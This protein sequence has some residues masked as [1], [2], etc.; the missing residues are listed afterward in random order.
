MVGR[1]PFK[2]SRVT[3]EH[4]VQLTWVQITPLHKATCGIITGL[5]FLT[6]KCNSASLKKITWPLVLTC[7]LGA[8]AWLWVAELSKFWSDLITELYFQKNDSKR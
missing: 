7:I 4:Y 5:S 1:A 6:G 2:R 8:L 3:V